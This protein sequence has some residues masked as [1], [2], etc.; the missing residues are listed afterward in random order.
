MT[1]KT[2]FVEPVVHVL[3]WVLLFGF[4]F[5]LETG[6]GTPDW[7]NM[8]NRCSIPIAFCIVFYTNYCI[9]MPRFLFNDRKRAWLCLNALLILVLSIALRLW[10]WCF[11][12]VGPIPVPAPPRPDGWAPY[13]GL[14]PDVEI[15]CFIRDTF[16]LCL[17][18]F[19]AL[20]IQYVRQWH[21]IENARKEA[22]LMN[23]KNQLNPHF[24][25]NTLN[26]IYALIIFDEGR[27]QKAVLD[28]CN[29]LRYVLYETRQDMVFLYKEVDFLKNYVALMKMR[30]S[31]SVDVE[32]D[33]GVPEESR[34]AIAPLLFIS[35]V[36][37]AFKHGIDPSGHSVIRISIKEEESLI[38][39]SVVNGYH[40]KGSSDRS[41]SGI[42]LEQLARRLEI[43]YPG[44]YE[45]TYGCDDTG[46]WYSSVLTIRKHS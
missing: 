42:G 9:L 12:F 41:G 39:C 2:G 31:G 8:L 34:T 29:L 10:Q 11:F 21:K 28:L 25:L 20:A 27:A 14:R 15:I 43:L 4:P 30:F 36:E 22:E 33:I 40:P 26:N 35:L 16:S 13:T 45:W 23:L 3:V 5:L 24:L 37:N 6:H 44:R 38:R 7:K 32:M 46:K 17:I 19:L 18:A 1:G